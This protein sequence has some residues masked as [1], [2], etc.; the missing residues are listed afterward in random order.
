M[1]SSQPQGLSHFHSAMAGR[2]GGAAG[3]GVPAASLASSTATSSGTSSTSAM[4]HSMTLL[5]NTINTSV[6]NGKN[7][8]DT[9]PPGA[10]KS[11]IDFA[12]LGTAALDFAQVGANVVLVFTQDFEAPIS[13][14]LAAI[15]DVLSAVGDALSAGILATGIISDI[16]GAISAAKPAAVGAAA[17][18]AATAA[19]PAATTTVSDLL[20]QVYQEAT[21]NTTLLN[22]VFQNAKTSPGGLPASFE[23]QVLGAQV[24]FQQN[25]DL[26]LNSFPTQV[27]AA[28]ET[29]PGLIAVL[30]ALLGYQSSLKTTIY[31][32]DLS[33]NYEQA[34]TLT[35]LNIL[36]VTF[37]EY[38]IQG[39]SLAAFF[40][41]GFA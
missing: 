30:Q 2:L 26:V 31:R 14:A 15:G 6:T 32:I 37:D 12:A 34:I 19:A 4:W 11:G 22:T 41:A 27:S 25:I 7:G 24:L 21:A 36:L 8:V 1:T 29:N 28:N 33:D 10:A 20:T 35:G 40:Y 23:T 18:A 13:E 9:A 38:I 39:V 17:P 16:L 5:N 3:A